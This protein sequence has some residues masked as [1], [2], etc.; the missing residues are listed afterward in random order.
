[1]LNSFENSF[2]ICSDIILNSFGNSF[3]THSEV[4]QSSLIFG[5]GVIQNSFGIHSDESMLDSFRTHAG[6]IKS[7]INLR[8]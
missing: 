2:M 5:A 6:V 4:I 7:G 8:V 1:M 3:R